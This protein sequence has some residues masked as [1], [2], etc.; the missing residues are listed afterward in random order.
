MKKNKLFKILDDENQEILNLDAVMFS[1]HVLHRKKIALLDDDLH[2]QNLVRAYLK[3]WT[4]FKGVTIESWRDP[5][6]ALIDL[7]TQNYDLAIIDIN[8]P[9][10]NG[11]SIGEVISSI[12]T[13]PSKIIYTSSDKTNL[14]KFHARNVSDSFY[15]QKPFV[16][17][18]LVNMLEKSG[19]IQRT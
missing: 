6:S 1:K 7:I 11:F 9:G 17:G 18:D 8:L 19:I 12:K 15:L 16:A 5:S 14:L 2:F 13:C 3:T 10:P 4:E